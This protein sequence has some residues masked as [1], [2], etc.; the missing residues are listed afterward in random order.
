MKGIQ[1]LFAVIPAHDGLQMITAAAFDVFVLA[2]ELAHVLALIFF[3]SIQRKGIAATNKENLIHHRSWLKCQV[4]KNLCALLHSRWG[5]FF[6]AHLYFH[7]F[8]SD[9]MQIN[10]RAM[11][12]RALKR[13]VSWHRAYTLRTVIRALWRGRPD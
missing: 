3:R 6:Q 13:R 11:H 8:Q 10:A 4:R 7:I 5:A 2:V 9:P 12:N 1:F